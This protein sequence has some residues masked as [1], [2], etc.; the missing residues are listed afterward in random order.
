M[1]KFGMPLIN[2]ID[3]EHKTLIKNMTDH[4]SLIR[5]TLL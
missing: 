1:I 4:F 2:K 3:T 5:N